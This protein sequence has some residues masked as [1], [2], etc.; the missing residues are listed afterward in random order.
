VAWELSWYQWEV[1]AAA[2]GNGVRQV[3]K[4]TD[5]SEIPNP[6]PR[7]NASARTDGALALG[8]AGDKA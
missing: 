5:I 3:A 8:K 6:E 7:W 4:G 2:E 1:G